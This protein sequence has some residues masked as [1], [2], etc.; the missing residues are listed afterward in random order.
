MRIYDITKTVSE[1]TSILD[2][3]ICDFHD[4][5]EGTTKQFTSERF[6]YHES[7]LNNIKSRRIF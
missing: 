6:E 2:I 3:F 7:H 4:L 1:G 5:A